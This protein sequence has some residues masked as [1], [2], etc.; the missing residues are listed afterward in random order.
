MLMQI[1]AGHAQYMPDT[2]R[3]PL[4]S[5]LSAF[6]QLTDRLGSRRI[7]PIQHL[8]VETGGAFIQQ[9]DYFFSP[10]PVRFF[11]DQLPLLVA[12][13]LMPALFEN[14]FTPE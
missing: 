5:Q 13:A 6:D 4:R 11:I 2:I 9:V 12:Y 8:A 14:L 7:E 3:F 1:V 10:C